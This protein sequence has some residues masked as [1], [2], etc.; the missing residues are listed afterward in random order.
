MVIDEF[1][2]TPEEM[3]QIGIS[4]S[5]HFLNQAVLNTPIRNEINGVSPER[6][7]TFLERFCRTLAEHRSLARLAQTYDINWAYNF[8]PLEEFP[9]IKISASQILCPIPTMLLRRFCDGLYFDLVR[10]GNE[11]HPTFG[12]AYEDYVGDVSSAANSGCTFQIMKAEKYGP[13]TA[14]KDTVDWVLA[15][16]SATLFIE[17]KASRVRVAAKVD[18]LA[19]GSIDAELRKLAGFIAQTYATLSDALHGQY[20]TWKPAATPV[21][22]LIVTLDNWQRFGLIITDAISEHVM[23]AFENKGLDKDL[24]V[25][26]PYTLCTIE[27]FEQAIQIMAAVGINKFM[28]KKVIGEQARWELVTFITRFFDTEAIEYIKPLFGLEF[29]AFGGNG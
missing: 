6:C 21:Y 10:R 27:E 22:P 15:D 19:R 2:M 1:G 16:D 4:L 3:F 26:H 7:A 29:A 24:L 5:G 8:N 11:F 18:L 17:C 13:R 9:L 12:L 23:A 28:S 14:R 20:E 25:K